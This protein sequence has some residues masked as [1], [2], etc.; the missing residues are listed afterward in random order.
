MKKL[1]LIF[2]VI[3]LIFATSAV[4][5]ETITTCTSQYGGGQI[6]GSSTTTETITHTTVN[7]GIADMELWQIIAISGIASVVAYILYRATYRVY[8]LG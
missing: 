1:A 6:C 2:T 8:T 3:T 4:A 5:S 7:A